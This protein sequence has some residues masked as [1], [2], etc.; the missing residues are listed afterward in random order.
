ML[1]VVKPKYFVPVHG[2]QKHLSKHA[3]LA[4]SMGMPASNIIIADNGTQLELTDNYIKKIGTV[5]AGRVFVDGSGVGDVGSVVLKDRK[6]LAEDG[7]II[8]VA[9]LD[10]ATGELVSG[11]DVVSR[12]FVFVKEAGDLIKDAE[13]TAYETIMK[14]YDKKIYD[15]GTIKVRVRDDVSRLMYERTKRSP[16][17]LPILMEI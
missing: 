15:W 17:I 4:E 16:M 5:P 2:E 9:T 11:P 13:N 12:G 10:G 6:H 1:G 3:T 7:I 14:L 8:V